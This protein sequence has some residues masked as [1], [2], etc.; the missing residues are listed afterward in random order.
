M[1]VI[2]P[3]VSQFKSMAEVH[4]IEDLR[5]AVFVQREKLRKGKGKNKSVDL[6]KLSHEGRR[7]PVARCGSDDAGWVFTEEMLQR[8][9]VFATG[10]VDPLNNRHKLF[11][12]ICRINFSMRVRKINQIKRHYPTSNQLRQHQRYAEKYC[13]DAVRGKM[14][15]C[16]MGTVQLPNEKLLWIGRF[17]RWTAR[18]LYTM[19]WWKASRLFSPVLQ[20]GSVSNF[21]V[22][23]TFGTRRSIKGV[24][25]FLDAITHSDRKLSLN[26]RF[27]LES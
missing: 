14:R 11:C 17:L 20:I 22:D 9:E 7:N 8:A 24:G 18:G 12:L 19:V 4:D 10:P 2:E 13:L 25:G 6:C 21:N 15:K 23:H 26:F 3:G 16:F 5:L 27:Q 1:S